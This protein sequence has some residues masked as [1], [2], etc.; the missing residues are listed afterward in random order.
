MRRLDPCIFSPMDGR[1]GKCFRCLLSLDPASLPTLACI[2]NELQFTETERRGHFECRRRIHRSTIETEPIVR[3][4][5][6][7]LLQTRKREASGRRAC[8]ARAPPPPT[9]TTR[10]IA[11]LKLTGGR[12][13]NNNQSGA[14]ARSRHRLVYMAKAKGTGRLRQ[15]AALMHKEIAT[16]AKVLHSIEP[17]CERTDG[18]MDE[19]GW[20]II[21][22][23]GRRIRAS[24]PPS[25]CRF[26]L[27]R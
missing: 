13:G 17:G 7:V 23:S 3:S 15:L 25:L 14:A 4:A 27:L 6:R 11:L 21:S 20:D 12:S 10:L 1:T 9:T 2:A 19:R 18:R 24:Q 22:A 5:G 26:L 8:P 16:M